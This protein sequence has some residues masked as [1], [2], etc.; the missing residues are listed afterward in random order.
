MT[1]LKRKG[2]LQIVF[3]WTKMVELLKHKYLCRTGLGFHS[4]LYSVHGF[5]FISTKIIFKSRF[6][7][8]ST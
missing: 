2:I 1:I 8:L 4:Q 3:I 6:K 7:I 5:H